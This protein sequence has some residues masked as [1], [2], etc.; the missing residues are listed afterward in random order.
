[1]RPWPR[2]WA[3]PDEREPSGTTAWKAASEASPAYSLAR[4]HVSRVISACDPDPPI[5]ARIIA[6]R[7]AYLTHY[8]EL[9]GANRSL[10]DLVLELRARGE[11]EP[12]V[13]TPRE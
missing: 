3:P 12:L 9:Y 5:E 4:W 11:V 1:M 6:M 7:I 13:I 10:L 8:T 2:D